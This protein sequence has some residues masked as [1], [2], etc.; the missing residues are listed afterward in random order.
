MQT[1]DDFLT[2]ARFTWHWARTH[3]AVALAGVRRRVVVGCASCCTPR[4]E[5]AARHAECFPFA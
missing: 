4:I 1:A 5:H 2:W 3:L